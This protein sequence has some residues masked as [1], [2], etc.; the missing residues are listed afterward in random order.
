MKYIINSKNNKKISKIGLGT[1]RFGT[2]VA[3]ES[4]FEM[5]DY[6]HL[7]GGTLVDTARVY[8]QWVAGGEGK[9]EECIGRWLSSRKCRPEICIATKGGGSQ[10]DGKID[11]SFNSLKQEL[12][13]SM[14]ALQ[15]DY[16]D[17]Y[18]IHKDN[19][20]FS[21]EEI[22]NTMQHLRE[23]G[24]ISLIGVAN[25]SVERV[26]AANAYAN[27]HGLEPFRF[28]QTW[29]SLAE[30]TTEMWDDETTTHMSLDMYNYMIEQN[31][32]GMAYTSQCKGYFQKAVL[33]GIDTIPS[34]LKY[35]IDT[36]VNRKKVDYIKNYCINSKISPTAV[37][38]GYITNNDL[39]GIALVST[40][41]MKQLED[42]IKWCSF[43]LPKNIIND[44]DK[45]QPA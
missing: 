29:W 2:V 37:V 36:D 8:N 43:T 31:M 5:L 16:I 18:M 25:W 22:V 14:L 19:T 7:H 1:A 24:N 6:F 27:S 34:F 28:V 13:Q 3:E 26:K 17:M 12:Q 21:V 39:E 30:Y 40:S 11:L 10:K 4:A 15:T 42:I 41:N 9:S 33:N 32:F 45:I 23:E 20:Q 44:L 38:Q 35:R